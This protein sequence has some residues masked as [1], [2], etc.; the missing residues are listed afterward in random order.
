MRSSFLR[1]SVG[2]LALFC[3]CLSLACAVPQLLARKK[4]KASDSNPNE[5]KRAVQALNRALLLVR[6]GIGSLV[7]L[8]GKQLRNRAG[9]AQAQTE[10]RKLT[11]AGSQKTGSH[12]SSQTG[13]S[14]NYEPERTKKLLS[15]VIPTRRGNDCR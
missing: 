13:R 12:E 9:E 14:T 3:L 15:D 11:N 6:I 8:S 4:D 7:F 5:Q 2:K 1:S 10:Q